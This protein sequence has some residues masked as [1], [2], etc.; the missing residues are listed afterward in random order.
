MANL[1]DKIE[2]DI[3]NIERVFEEMPALKTLLQLSTLEL[4]GVA[5]LLHS[6]YNGSENIIKRILIEK[7][8]SIPQGSSW[9]KELLNVAVD[10]GIISHDVKEKLGEFLAFR[11]FFSHAYAIDIYAERMEP[12]VKSVSALYEK[13]KKEIAKTY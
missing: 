12:L 11:H 9:H 7:G 8:V 4:A 13:F 6:F 10:E 2:I 1:R 3:E 5:A